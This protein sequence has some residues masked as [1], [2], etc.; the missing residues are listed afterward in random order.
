MKNVC[1]S[2][3]VFFLFSS[4]IFAQITF[5][6]G[7]YINQSNQKIECFIKNEDW[8]NTPSKFEYKLSTD[9]E[10]KILRKNGFKTLVINDAFKF[11]T[12]TVPFDAS[13][14][15]IANL[16]YERSP[17]LKDT[18][19][20]LNVLIEGKATLYEFSDGDKRAFFYKKETNEMKPLIYNVYTNENRD[21]LYNNRYQQQLMTELSCGN[22]NEKRVS[23]IDYKAG[24]LKSFFLDYNTC[25]GGTSVEFKKNK[26]A[27][28][29]LK[30]FAGVYNGSAVTDLSAI[31]FFR[32]GIESEV[33]WSPTFGFEVEYVFPFNKNKWSMFIAPNYSSY[34]GDSQFYDLSIN[35][36]YTLEYSAIQV[37]L[38]FKHYMFL[39]DTSK[40]FLSG[41]VVMD[42][43]LDAKG[44]GNYTIAKDR[45]STSAGVALG[46]G[47]SYDAY[48][49]E[50]RYIPNRELLENASQSSVKLQ[51]FSI[52]IGY[53]IF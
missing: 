2:L 52:T 6:K 9:G 8:I 33:T 41:A 3:F 50:A 32:G 45:F 26:K 27:I 42:F 1:L 10:V 29:H 11:E 31:T 21:I 38:G 43:L 25:E 22:V 18:L 35:R 23:R 49:I 16:T 28:F 40:L 14:K 15:A 17:N 47:Y 46:I 19:L 37:P 7:Y 12:H 30:A 5:E 34:K 44:S 48:S 53:T 39:N 24:D 13:S 20:I 4:K 36:K 51:Q